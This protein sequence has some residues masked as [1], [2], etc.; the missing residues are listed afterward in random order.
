MK[1]KGLSNTINTNGVL[2]NFT[3]AIAEN[4]SCDE[5]G[6]MDVQLRTSPGPLP[7]LD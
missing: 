7:P 5:L 3:A 4:E 1:R 6:T 2:T